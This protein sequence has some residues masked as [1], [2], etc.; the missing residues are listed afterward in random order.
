MTIKQT[1][2]LVFGLLFALMAGTGILT[3]S[4]FVT[5]TEHIHEMVHSANEVTGK[6]LPLVKAIKDIKM[7]AAQV[8]LW[9]TDISATRGQDGLDDGYKEA[10]AAAQSF[11]KNVAAAKVLAQELGLTGVVSSL[12]QVRADFLP[13]YDFGKKMAAAYVEKGPPGGNKMMEDFDAVAEKLSGSL[14]KLIEEV[15]ANT[16]KASKDLQEAGE[17]LASSA[18]TMAIS[19][20]LAGGVVVCVLVLALVLL[21]KR[22]LGP[23]LDLTEVMG[24]MADGNLELTVPCVGRSDETGKMA[25]AV[26]IFRVSGQKLRQVQ[27]ASEAESRR[28]Q[29]KLQSQLLALNHALEEEVSK[30][31]EVV[32]TAAQSMRGSADNMSSAIDAVQR[33][34]ETAAAASEQATGSVNAVAAAA[35]ELS[36][37]VQEISRQVSQSTSIAHSAEDEASRA[38]GM[39]QSL[40]KSAESVGE[41]VHLINDIASQTNLLALNA[42][43]EAARAG[44]AGKGFAVVANEVKSLANQTAKATDEISGQITAIQQATQDAVSAIEGIAKTISQMNA[45]AAGIASAVEEQSAATQEIARSASQAAGGTQEA[46]SNI[47][48]VSRSSVET[49]SIAGELKSSAVQVNDRI[50]GMQQSMADIMRSSSEDNKRLNERHTINLPATAVCDG[51][52]I[53]CLLHDLSLSGAGVLDRALEGVKRGAVLSVKLA[54]LGEF[55]GQVMALTP[56]STHISLEIEEASLSKVEQF[57]QSRKKAA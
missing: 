48:E 5:Q 24:K 35:E 49:S 1:F 25:S 19:I 16:E 27:A 21:N 34:S 29:R 13:F 57:I 51:R 52:E 20:G 45:I 28:N 53:S 4:L 15:D 3:A 31:V 14:D 9:L 11:E 40:A 12:D 2:S 32:L 47:S 22:L 41:V 50:V 10:E 44:D 23:M 39:V 26:E 56:T 7:D 33:Q 42:T 30:T 6:D 38:T 43:I 37:S 17:T 18:N 55:S 36:S 8:S 54:G 46:S